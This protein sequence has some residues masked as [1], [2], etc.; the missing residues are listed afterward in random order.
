MALTIAQLTETSAPAYAGVVPTFVWSGTINLGTP[1][2][3]NGIA[4]AAAD[5]SARATTIKTINIAD[6]ADGQVRYRLN[7]AGTKIVAFNTAGNE[8][9]NATNLSAANF[10]AFMTVTFI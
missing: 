1:Y 3:T 2:A 4:I 8:L 9:A 10:T 5:I 7:A 6:S